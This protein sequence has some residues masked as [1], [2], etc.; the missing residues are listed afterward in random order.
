MHIFMIKFIPFYGD[1]THLDSFTSECEEMELG[2]CTSYHQR[3]EER[4]KT[5]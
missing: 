3:E 5:V 2:V 4:K 1:I